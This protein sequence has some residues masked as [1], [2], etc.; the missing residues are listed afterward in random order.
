MLRNF[1]ASGQGWFWSTDADGRLTY[2]TEN[3]SQSFGKRPEEL[4]GS[5]FS[6]LFARPDDANNGRGALPLTLA[7]LAPFN[8]LPLRAAVPDAACYWSVS[9]RP[10]FDERGTFTGY[11]G[12]GT[13]ITEQRETSRHASKLAKYDSLTGLPNRLQM[14]QVLEANLLA[15]ER[16]KKPCAVMLVD[17]DRFKQVNDTLGHPAGDALLKQ[18][19]DRL[20][21]IV[22]DREHVFRV[23]GDEFKVVLQNCEDRGVIGCKA[24]EII[25]SLSQPYWVDGSR[26]IIGASIGLAVG[27]LD[28]STSEELIRNADLA[29]YAA[30]TGGRGRFRFFSGELLQAAEDRRTLEEDL[31]DSL[32]KG[33]ISLAYQ[34][35]INAETNRLNGVEALIRWHHPER[36]DISPALFIPIAEETDL[37]GPLGEWVLRKA[38]EDAATWPG[39][40]RVA[41]NVS[42]IQFMNEALPSKV[43]S[44][45]AASGLLPNRLELEITEGVFLAEAAETD[46]MFAKLKEIGVRLALDDFGTGYSSLGYLRSAPFDKIKIDQTF[47]S[48]A[49]LPGSR[50][51]A[52]IA[53]IVALAGA[54]EMETTAEGIEY[55]DQLHLVRSLGVSHVQGFV[56]SQ[57]ISSEDLVR[58]LEKGEWTIAP[59]GPA[60]QRSDR[61]TMYRKVGVITGSRYVSVLIRNLSETG[62]LIEGFGHFEPGA[63]L[64]LNFGDGQLAFA[65]VSRAAG[66]GQGIAFDHPLVSDGN[67]G[68]CTRHR[69]SPYLLGTVGLPASVDPDKEVKANPESWMPLEE[70]VTKLGLAMVPGPTSQATGSRVGTGASEGTNIVEADRDPDAG[71]GEGRKPHAERADEDRRTSPSK[72]ELK[73]P[74]FEQL[75]RLFLSKSTSDQG[76]FA[77]ISQDLNEHILPNFGH[78]RLNRLAQSG[79][80]AALDPEAGFK[81]L[82]P[83]TSDRLQSTVRQMCALAVQLRLPGSETITLPSATGSGKHVVRGA[84]LSPAQAKRLLQVAHASP[85]PQLKFVVALLMLTGVKQ[86]ELLN[87]HWSQIDFETSTWHVPAS[88]AGEARNLSM[89]SSTI[90]LLRALPRWGGCSFIIAN[91][92]T[93]RSYRSF[94]RSWDSARIKAGLPH[95]EINDLSFFDLA[96]LLSSE[97]LLD[98]VIV[99]VQAKNPQRSAA[100]ED[101]TAHPKGVGDNRPLTRAA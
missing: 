10:Q 63:P 74:T 47:V 55:M 16:Y 65:R 35:I 99:P 64:L 76:S 29:L 101:T 8:R 75:S 30:K 7:K 17:L 22:G 42:P 46:A 34:P 94:A 24:T 67:G 97:E 82:P 96:G 21:G 77:R 1:E 4:L 95:M 85:N 92:H 5:Q 15:A 70:L 11:R 43:L 18:V 40:I 100:S 37:I 26:C 2:L 69:V 73:S 41:V 13:D 80:L 62:A 12:S 68:L 33:Q 51:S 59:T 31:R 60:R 52:I 84:V 39:Q 32:A 57:A 86:T 25:A 44:A 66:K 90:A 23:G 88:K 19:A 6:E 71:D 3:V 38:C 9:G 49:T 14:M 20:V 28:G 79:M 72:V 50:N 56:Y 91:P 36:G 53:A 87:A 78:V 61:Q 89:S 81:G 48:E 98:A 27:P 45:L 54:L 93:G 58:R 83:G